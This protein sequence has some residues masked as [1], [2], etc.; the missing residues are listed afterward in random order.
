M[1]FSDLL[2]VARIEDGLFVNSFARY[3]SYDFNTHPLHFARPMMSE[4]QVEYIIY[5][6]MLRRAKKT[7][8]SHNV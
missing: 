6:I 7:H 4:V 2:Y 5:Y 8:H 1:E 3:I